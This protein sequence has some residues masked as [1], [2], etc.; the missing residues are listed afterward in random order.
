[1]L[2]VRETI[3]MKQIT[4]FPHCQVSSKASSIP[5]AASSA[6]WTCTRSL[7]SGPNSRSAPASA[8]GK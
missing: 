6:R 4:R 5:A 7:V 3:R 1:V 2:N 8:A